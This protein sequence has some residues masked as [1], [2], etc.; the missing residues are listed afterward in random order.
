MRL[1]EGG[2]GALEV[3]FSAGLQDME[4]HPF[5]ARRLLRLS[6][7]PLDSRSWMVWVT[8]R[9]ITPAWGTSSESSS[10]RFRSSSLSKKLMPVTLP[11]G[12]LK[13]ATRP[14]PTGSPTPVKTIGIV[15]VAF[16]DASA[17]AGP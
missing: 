2:E 17:P 10:S 8:S 15:E 7:L 12:R 5:R 4:L 16:F 11:P 3:A 14:T 6:Y 9:A 1:E 13:L